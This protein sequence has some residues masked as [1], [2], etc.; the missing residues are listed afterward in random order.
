VTLIDTSSW[1]EFLRGSDSEPA[2][3]VKELL[4]EDRAAW[5]DLIAVELWNGTR[6]HEKNAL[7]D[8]ASAVTSFDL[9]SVVWARAKSLAYS[10][11][12]SGLTVPANDIIITACAVTHELAIESFDRHFAKILPLAQKI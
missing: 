11:R 10:C 1:I 3:R 6:G 9:T 5:C 2:F 12:H 4:R 7:E 8:L